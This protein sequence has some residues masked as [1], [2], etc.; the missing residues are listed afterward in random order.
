MDLAKWNI[1]QTRNTPRKSLIPDLSLKEK[2][3]KKRQD[4]YININVNASSEFSLPMYT[5]MFLKKLNVGS[6]LKLNL[7]RNGSLQANTDRVKS[8]SSFGKAKL[9]R[10]M[11]SQTQRKIMS[12][13]LSYLT[14]TVGSKQPEV[15]NNP[16]SI[17]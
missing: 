7:K 2:L 17:V 13:N 6:D 11:P 4:N 14:L 15:Y 12:R 10:M 1:T 9:S 8:N 5:K 3:I 16:K